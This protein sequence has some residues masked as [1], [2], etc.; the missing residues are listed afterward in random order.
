MGCVLMG[1]EPGGNEWKRKHSGASKWLKITNLI[2]V[3][4]APL[5]I[6]AERRAIY[7]W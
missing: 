2:L 5:K 7:I 6:V 4:D 3:S 1:S